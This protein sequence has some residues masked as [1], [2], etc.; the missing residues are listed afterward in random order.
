MRHNRKAQGL[1]LVKIVTAAIV[2]LVLV[3]V[4]LIGPGMIQKGFNNL[5]RAVGLA[6]T[7]EGAATGDYILQAYAEPVD[8][9]SVI[10]HFTPNPAR[11]AEIREN[12]PYRISQGFAPYSENY[13]PDSEYEEV[14]VLGAKGS[15]GK[16]RLY[17]ADED[18][19]PI[20]L[21][22]PGEYGTHLLRID[23]Y[24]E[25]QGGFPLE[26]VPVEVNEWERLLMTYLDSPM[27]DVGRGSLS[28]PYNSPISWSLAMHT[29]KRGLGNHPEDQSMNMDSGRLRDVKDILG[30]EGSTIEDIPD[31]T[32]GNFKEFLVKLGC[33]YPAG[34]PL[35][36]QLNLKTD[37]MQTLVTAMFG[38]L[39]DFN[40][41]SGEP[42]SPD[43]PVPRI[44][45]GIGIRGYTSIVDSAYKN[46]LLPAF[47]EAQYPSSDFNNG[48]TIFG[49]VRAH[50]KYVSWKPSEPSATRTF[51]TPQD[52]CFGGRPITLN[53]YVCPQ[54]DS[55]C[56]IESVGEEAPEPDEPEPQEPGEMGEGDCYVS[57][58]DPCGGSVLYIE[59]GDW[60]CMYDATLGVEHA[61]HCENGA[62]VE[63][64]D[65]SCR[66]HACE[67]SSSLGESGWGCE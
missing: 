13:I 41:E 48:F 8:E 58:M 61:R 43:Q 40:E 44:R 49:Q 65:C 63:V 24:G 50:G 2:L 30:L 3:V 20:A 18:D 6:P 56:R 66:V 16:E 51:D 25:E 37:T 4:A 55:A 59:D 27:E 47:I 29:E 67:M 42:D 33:A 32:G 57:S 53:M 19:E 21:V 62:I 38:D 22:H 46:Q 15:C 14:G 35:S 60:I 11:C 64:K 36:G 28:D 12:N 23:V 39:Q 54:S 26:S 10:L 9:G 31:F 17:P 45:D 52:S 34:H 5:L 7:E 1:P